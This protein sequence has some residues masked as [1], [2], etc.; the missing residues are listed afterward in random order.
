[1]TTSLLFIDRIKKLCRDIVKGKPDALND[2]HSY[3]I[4]IQPL[5]MQRGGPKNSKPGLHAIKLRAAIAAPWVSVRAGRDM[6]H[7]RSNLG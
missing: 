4:K 1:M 6:E 5:S 7:T 3:E 2:V